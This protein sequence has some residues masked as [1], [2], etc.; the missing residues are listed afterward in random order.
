MPLCNECPFPDQ[1]AQPAEMLGR[2]YLA[3]PVEELFRGSSVDPQL[4]G[5]DFMAEARRT[6]ENIAEVSAPFK[7]DEQCAGPTNGQCPQRQIISILLDR[8]FRN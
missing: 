4:I 6:R 3:K 7:G 5:G 1:R 2:K 8:R